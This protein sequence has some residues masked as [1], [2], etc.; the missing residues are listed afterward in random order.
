MPEP[1]T[2]VRNAGARLVE[3]V[4]RPLQAFIRLEAASGSL[5]LLS[6]VAA[7]VWANA[8]PASYRA[9]LDYEVSSPVGAFTARAF[10]NDGL[11][12]VFFFVVGMEIKRELVVGELRTVAAATLPAIA[13][14]GGM[15]FPAGVFLAWNWDGTGRHGWGIPVAT[16]IAFC[17][18]VLTLLK[19]H[20]PRALVVFAM[21]LAIFDDIGGILIIAFFYGHGL[22]VPWLLGAGALTLLLG[23][24]NR[25]GVKHGLAYALVGAALWYAV[26][27]GGIH[28]TIAGVVLGL[29]IPADGEHAPVD[30]FIHRLHPYVAFF[31]MP[32]FALANSGVE[33]GG[34]VGIAS[35]ATPVGLGTAGGLFFGK[36]IGIFTFTVLAVRLGLAPMPGNASLTKLYGVSV[37]A[38]IGFTVAL[39]IAALAYPTHPEHLDQAKIGILVGSIAA[40]LVA[41]VLL[42][43]S[44][45]DVAKSPKGD[46][47][48][49]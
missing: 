41:F 29:S 6:A 45:R 38:G 20:V 7:L 25:F 1:G 16:D 10:I 37:A 46:A 26:H 3:A 32:V 48:Q 33:L 14:L 35:L 40:G 5:L 4:T 39:F 31:V 13:A 11:M 8:S 43:A 17:V 15:A 27:H 12:T 44:S 34:G 47:P 19:H 18:G 2:A 42:R 21:A 23:V 9:M 28:V 22:S 36:Q 49:S 24:M 30:R